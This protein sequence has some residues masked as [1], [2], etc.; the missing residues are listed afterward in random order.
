MDKAHTHIPH[1]TARA[2]AWL[3]DRAGGWLADDEGIALQT[4]LIIAGLVT[5][6]VIIAAVLL[7]AA[8]DAGDNLGSEVE[9]IESALASEA[10]AAIGRISVT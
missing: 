6:A 7:N 3:K 1:F 5:V 9:A 2:V 10:S 4:V 8:G